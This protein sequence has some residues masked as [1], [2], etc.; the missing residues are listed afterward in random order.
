MRSEETPRSKT[1]FNSALGPAPVL[2]LRCVCVC[3]GAWMCFVWGNVRARA[4]Y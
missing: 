1:I 3:T 4:V 2:W